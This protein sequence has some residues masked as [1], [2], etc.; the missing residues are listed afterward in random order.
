MSETIDFKSLKL[1]DMYKLRDKHKERKYVESSFKC[2]TVKGQSQIT[3]PYPH[4]RMIEYYMNNLNFVNQKGLLV[5]HGLGSGKTCASIIAASKNKIFKHIIVLLPA[6][7]K[8]N[9]ITEIKEKCLSDGKTKYLDIENENEIR[10]FSYNSTKIPIKICETYIKTEKKVDYN[11]LLRD[12][13]SYDK[14]ISD[15]IQS[16]HDMNK[17]I[18]IVIDEAHHIFQTITNFKLKIT[19]SETFQ[20][21]LGRFFYDLF[22]NLNCKILFLTGTPLT[23]YAYEAA[24]IG[25]LCHGYYYP[26]SRS[27]TL[28]PENPEVFYQTYIDQKTNKLQTMGGKRDE[29]TRKFYGIISYFPNIDN[30]DVFPELN[31]NNTTLNNKRE[32]RELIRNP[33]MSTTNIIERI[34]N[35][36]LKFEVH[37][38][39]FYTNP[40]S[41]KKSNN[42][43]NRYSNNSQST[44]TIQS[45]LPS[46]QYD[47]Y[48][49]YLSK[50][51]EE[52]K[53]SKRSKV[54][55][56]LSF[57]RA[58]N[59]ISSFRS[60]T[61]ISSNFVYPYHF[62]YMIL[63][64]IY[65]FGLGL[66]QSD[67]KTLLIDN[68]L[69]AGKV[70]S[71]PLDFTIVWNTLHETYEDKK[72][73]DP[74]LQK[75]S[76]I[77]VIRQL[78]N[79]PNINDISKIPNI[80]NVF[81]DFVNQYHYITPS[82]FRYSFLRKSDRSNASKIHTDFNRVL[83][84]FIELNGK[85]PKIET[86]TGFGKS[87]ETVEYIDPVPRIYDIFKKYFTNEL[88]LQTF[89]I[90]YLE[91]RRL[92]NDIREVKE[93]GGKYRKKLFYS[94]YKNQ[95]GTRS[96]KWLLNSMGYE[97][98]I[99]DYSK[100]SSSKNENNEFTL[101]NDIDENELN[102]TKDITSN[103]INNSNI[104]RKA[105]LQNNSRIIN[106]SN[107]TGKTNSRKFIIF[108][109][110][111]ERR[112]KV[113]DEFNNNPDI[114][115]I[116]ISTAGSEGISLKNVRDVFIL[117]PYWNINRIVQ[118]IGRAR[119]ICSHK[120]L[121]EDERKVKVYKFMAIHPTEL[122]ST[123]TMID[124]LSKNKKALI[125]DITS[126]FEMIAID[127]PLLQGKKKKVCYTDTIDFDKFSLQNIQEVESSK[128]M[129]LYKFYMDKK[130]TNKSKL[131][132]EL[133]KIFEDNFKII[134]TSK[135]Q[136]KMRKD[137]LIDLWNTYVTNS[138]KNISNTKVK[139]IRDVNDL[140]TYFI[141]P[142]SRNFYGIGTNYRYVAKVIEEILNSKLVIEP[143]F[144]RIKDQVEKN[145][146]KYIISKFKL[147]KQNKIHQSQF[148]F[149]DNL[150]VLL[151]I[152]QSWIN[153]LILCRD[154]LDTFVKYDYIRNKDFN[155]TLS[156]LLSYYKMERKSDSG[157]NINVINFIKLL[158]KQNI[159]YIA[160]NEYMDKWIKTMDF[161]KKT[162]NDYFN[163]NNETII[164][165]LIIEMKNKEQTED[166]KNNYL[167]KLCNELLGYKDGKSF[168]VTE[169]IDKI[170]IVANNICINDIPDYTLFVRYLQKNSNYNSMSETLKMAVNDY[171][172]K[173]ILYLYLVHQ[174]N[175][176]NS[177]L[178]KYNNN[179]KEIKIIFNDILNIYYRVQVTRE[180]VATLFN[181]KSSYDILTLDVTSDTKRSIKPLEKC[182]VLL[183]VN[184]NVSSRNTNFYIFL[185]TNE[186]KIFNLGEILHFNS[187]RYFLQCNIKATEDE[188]YFEIDM[189]DLLQNQVFSIVELKEK[190][191]ILSKNIS[192]VI[193]NNEPINLT[194]KL[195]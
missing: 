83:Q 13:K 95:A 138:S 106:T 195:N 142:Q 128:N 32:Y 8:P 66:P 113:I 12:A 135:F 163:K 115:I 186:N 159:P 9:Y 4:Q 76:L 177:C 151:N 72:K 17:S 80:V 179:L 7:L 81:G 164:S 27:G 102:D 148:D 16:L 145:K 147:L 180:D 49:Y 30:I 133:I 50:E 161:M 25:N 86:R 104:D 11:I 89:S 157:S 40:V 51:D 31:I 175:F 169:V 156:E 188:T 109:G 176:I 20:Y 23:N 24:I 3:E 55:S 190:G 101:I 42:V 73:T 38:L 160:I 41:I 111:N 155:D 39:P 99:V 167:I 5:F 166:L 100:T 34:R 103:D 54:R 141:Y 1:S 84:Y 82:N 19:S 121:P 107:T 118:V 136:I 85:Y 75:L 58:E 91:I 53:K 87:S 35:L 64:H 194:I 90:K 56:S 170:L 98:A 144:V 45:N 77:T 171:M 60:N 68:I 130:S 182:T 193:Q 29:F 189:N 181:Y 93:K 67:A 137:V 96:I 185:M 150:F 2:D 191:G 46:T 36:R 123:D 14:V 117:E 162:I 21:S 149:E 57:M 112:K 126:V 15:L 178:T 62:F 168:K 63:L 92:L 97:E 127:C 122:K 94:F 48:S 88:W 47:I 173:L 71:I 143:F 74:N 165:N 43:D 153:D 158:E 120:N 184:P 131:D 65:L 140:Y 129:Y 119:R 154:N 18:F 10:L 78:E 134:L 132:S 146:Q 110:D 37:Q 59:E 174:C 183:A 70:V 28:F 79:I 52:Q 69:I 114:D 125:E 187:S 33:T 172:Y 192:T 124:N 61:R 6:F 152:C 26:E 108:E 44:S 139:T 116:C 22:M 105:I